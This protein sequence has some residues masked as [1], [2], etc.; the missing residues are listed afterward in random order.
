MA[1][2]NAQLVALNR[3]EVSKL[4]L[5]RVDIEKLRLAADCQLNWEPRVIGPMTLRPGMQLVGEIRSDNQA[6]VIDFVYAK[7]DTAL[8]ELTAGEMRVWIDDVLLT[9]PSVATAVSDPTFQGGG[10]WSLADSTAG[11]TV[12]IGGG[13]LILEASPAGSLARAKQAISVAGGDQA[14]EHGLRIIVA[15]GPV[16]VRIGSSDGLADI[17]PQTSLDTGTH[18]LSF[19]PGAATLYLQIDST[20]Q[21]AKALTDCSFEA[22]GVVTVST[23]WD[24][25]DLANIRYTQAGDIIFVACYGQQQRM[26]QRRGIRPGARGWSVVTYYSATGPFHVSPDASLTLK[27][28]GL[29][30]NI[31]IGASKPFFTPGHVGA[32]LR[33]FTPQQNN[34]ILIGASNTF[35]YPTR[36]S[37]VQGDRNIAVIVGGTWTGVWSLQRSIDGPDSGFVT[38][39][40]GDTGWQSAPSFNANTNG[41]IF[42]DDQSNTAGTLYDNV[43]AW[44]RIGFDDGNYGSGAAYMAAGTNSGGGWGIARI[45]VFGSPTVVDAE[46][47]D[48]FTGISAASVWQI[49][50]WCP[51]FGWPTSV[52]FHEGRLFWFSG[53]GIPIAGSRSGQFYDYGVEDRLGNALGD[54]GAILE[55][56]GEG[57]SDRINWAL[58][59]TRLICGRETSIASIR[60]SS[61]DEPLTGTN[62]SVKDCATQGAARVRALK[63]DKRGVFVQQAGNRVYVVE[64]DAQA[65]DYSAHDLTRLNHDVALPGLLDAAVARQ[66]DTVA[67]FPR[68][69]GQCAALLYD[70]DDEVVAWTRIQTFGVIEC[71]RVLPAED[72]P[73]DEVYFVVK[74]VINGNTRRFIEKLAPRSNC[75]G[76]IINQLCDSH[77]VYSG[78][79]AT[80]IS[81]PHLPLT[82]VVIW[83]DGHF[84][85]TVTTDSNG[86][87]TFPNGATACGNI[88]AGLGGAVASAS[89]STSTPILSLTGLSAYE[90]LPCEL[91]SNQQPLGH[92]VHL[93]SAVVSGG[94][95]SLPPNI[96][97]SAVVAYFGFMAPFMSAKLAYGAQGGSALNMKKRIDHLGLVLYDAHASGLQF[98][99]RFD[100]LDPLPGIQDGDAVGANT[101]FS[102]FDV[103]VME[104]PGEW[105]TDAR[106]CLLGQAPFPVTVGGVVV[107]METN[108]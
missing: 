12:T 75:V 78:S 10:T 53:G 66:P 48:P 81:L 27:P 62:F 43:I 50:D 73:D 15:N 11:T 18:S 80:S 9:R 102:E 76:G 69:D 88:V 44:Y 37:G 4:A 31:T 105:D 97:G 96:G 86:L 68:T 36:I 45:G 17:L 101:V 30:G 19:V 46:V 63:V 83:G 64:F 3:G 77:L 14:Q 57:P 2:V 84:V 1:K 20:D 34:G 5:G 32:L 47:L 65:M 100:A 106:L 99:Q 49:S 42:N 91:F 38:I 72:G 59:L 28:N 92:M 25:G 39:Q 24:S 52:A 7:D 90:G 67:Y 41:I 85:G 51:A 98:G 95:V 8:L 93:G 22:A 89:S 79:A 94:T 108:G 107:S 58:P 13:E 26:I 104:V 6:T 60:S 55:D 82:S 21:W 74:R 33:L 103:P 61:F 54:S 70:P 29:D 35:T 71:V 40:A 87:A 56:F 23:T 16:M